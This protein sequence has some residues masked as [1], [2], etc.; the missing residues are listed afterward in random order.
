MDGNLIGTPIE[1][2]WGDIFQ[3]GSLDRGVLTLLNQGIPPARTWPPVLDRLL[4]PPVAEP[5]APTVIVTMDIG[6]VNE[7][8]IDHTMVAAVF[9]V[10]I[11]D[12]PDAVL[13]DHE[14]ILW[15]DTVLLWLSHGY[16]VLIHCA[17]GVSR[18][19]YLDCAVQMR[20]RH[21]SFD[22]A[23]AYIKASRPQ[24]N[25]NSGFVEQ[26]RRLEPELMKDETV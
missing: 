25:P 26:L 19:S 5:V 16:N 13:P 11:Q 21:V 6:E 22:D 23:L 14:L 17:A 10:W 18:S 20:G 7:S 2:G 8:L 4:T 1:E 12:S 3:S 9:S 15:T 24:A